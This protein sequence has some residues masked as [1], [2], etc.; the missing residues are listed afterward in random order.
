MPLPGRR[1]TAGLL[2]LGT[3]AWSPAAHAS[4][5]TA[6]VFF[7]TIP[8]CVGLVGVALLMGALLRP[9][10]GALLGLP[11]GLLAAIH[12]LLLPEMIHA[13]ERRLWAT[14]AAL[15]SLSLLSVA[16]L[17]RRATQAAR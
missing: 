5:M 7:F 14:Q 12:L 11:I 2:A 4:D 9:A 13:G 10:H 8:A 16:I 1:V 17:R 3:A 15:S 6:L